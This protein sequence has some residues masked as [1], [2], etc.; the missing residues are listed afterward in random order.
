M[1]EQE[2]SDRGYI[3]YVGSSHRRGLT[4][5]DFE[6]VGVSD[7]EDVYWDRGNDW[8]V[9]RGD[10]SDDAYN[11]AVRQDPELILVGGDKDE[12]AVNE[13][14]LSRKPLAAD[15]TPMPPIPETPEDVVGGGHIAPTGTT[16]TGTAGA[17]G[18]GTA[19]TTT[20]GGTGTSATG[21]TRTKPQ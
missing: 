21:S 17:T 19:G 2:K 11:R 20:G 14:E 18:T 5:E 15:M 3:Q 1:A 10:L 16:G 8:R 9:P 7:Q 12:G 6:S 13:D 4:R